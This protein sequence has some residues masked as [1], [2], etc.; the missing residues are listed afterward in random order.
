MQ[1]MESKFNIQI[2][3]HPSLNVNRMKLFI[4]PIFEIPP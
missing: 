4:Q 2:V 3:V 1:A